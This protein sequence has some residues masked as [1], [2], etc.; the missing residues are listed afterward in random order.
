VKAF[1]YAAVRSVDEAIAQVGADR[2]ATFVAGATELVNWMKDGIQ[3]PTRLVDI[4]ALPLTEVIVRAEGV[5]LGS[6]ARMSDVAAMAALRQAYPVLTQALEL[7]ASPQIRNMGTIGGNLLQRT[8]CPYFRETSF[9]C[10]KRQPGSG[11]AALSG[12]HRLHAI[13]GASGACIAVHPS[14]LAVALCALDAIVHT[15]GPAGERA[16]PLDRL[17]LAPGDTP[18]QETVLD[19]GEL[20][21]AV[22]V[23]ANACAAHSVY[24]KVRERASYEFALVSAAA[25]L[26]LVGETH[27]VRSARVVLGGVA[28]KPW[29]AFAAEDALVGQP[30]TEWSIAAAGAESVTRARP[31]DGNAFKV[32]LAE[33]AVIRALTTIGEQV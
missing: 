24:I 4:N 31:L 8:R 10:N 13:F 33:R 17:Y 1:E 23:P 12:E 28:F 19:H 2:N 11:C 15:R 20:I 22:V 21:L 14:D 3:S 6:L 18:Q 29:R 26:D 25:C 30:L 16:I 27:I 32:P 7:G 9:A 5:R